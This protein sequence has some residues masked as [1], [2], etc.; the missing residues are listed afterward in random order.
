MIGISVKTAATDALVS[1]IH[2]RVSAVA[3][4][5]SEINIVSNYVFDMIWVIVIDA[6]YDFF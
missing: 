2:T 1:V 4:Q 3:R 5:H 6:M